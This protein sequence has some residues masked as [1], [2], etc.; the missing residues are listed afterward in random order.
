MLTTIRLTPAISE[1]QI[2]A[3]ND[4][5]RAFVVK[6]SAGTVIVDAGVEEM[7]AKLV[8]T[9]RPLNPILLVVTHRHSDH[10]GGLAKIVAAMPDLVIAAHEDEA[11]ALPVLV[12]RRL[13]DGEEVVAGLQV[14]HVPGHTAGNIAL[15][16]VDEGTLITGDCVFGAGPQRKCLIP[17]PAGYC[18]DAKLAAENISLLLRYN[19]DRAILSHGEHLLEGARGKIA[20]LCGPQG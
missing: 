11:D 10:A 4:V 2:P 13:R 6:T 16:L 15:L 3:A 12:Q 17:P 18:D 9:I 8:A 7:A 19:F 20:A 5:F 1:I 14:I